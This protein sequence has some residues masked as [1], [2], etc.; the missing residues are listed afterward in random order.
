MSMKFTKMHGLGNDY[1]YVNCFEETVEN[2]AELAKVL[3]NRHTGIGGDGLIL[4]LPSDKA[5]AMMRIFNADGSE[6]M[7]CGNGLR[8]VGKFVH[9]RGLAKSGSITI[10]TLSGVKSLQ[11]REKHGKTDNVTVNMGAPILRPADIPMKAPGDSF[12]DCP[13]TVGGKSYNAT[14]VSMGNPHWVFFMNGIESLDLNAIGPNFENH[15]L[16][17]NRV[18]TEFVAVRD[19]ILHMR[20]YERGSGETMAC[21]TGACAVA[22]A[23]VLGGHAPREVTVRLLGG[24]LRIHWDGAD[25]NVYMTGPA[26]EVFTG[27]YTL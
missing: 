8:C 18:N 9:D 22:V 27:E 25:N 15:P 11:I 3:S 23:A 10:D 5:D 12:I 14:A 24:D 7:M 20:V 21:G 26:T 6:A 16:F 4:V 2:P 17:P 19:G 1:I 13:V